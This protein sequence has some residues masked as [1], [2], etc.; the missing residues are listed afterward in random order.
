MF[1]LEPARE[2]AAQGHRTSVFFPAPRTVEERMRRVPQSLRRPVGAMYWFG[3]VLPRRIAQIAQVRRFD[4]IVL[5]CGLLRAQSVPLLDVLLLSCA[6][7]LGV[8]SVYH[9]DDALYEVVKPNRYAIRCRL[10]DRVATGNAAIAAFASSH[11]GRV[12]R[13]EGWIDADAYAAAD[14][15][16]RA[17][18]IGWTGH[19]PR[20][21]LRPLLNVFRR[22][23]DRYGVTIRVIGDEVIDGGE[24]SFIESELWQQRHE[25]R[26]FADFDIGVMPL[27]N[28]PYN[29]GKEA[30]KLKEYM[31]AGL[32]VVCSPVG[33]NLS[34]VEE[35]RT[36][37]FAT[38]EDEW[39]LALTRL[40]LDRDLRIALGTAGRERALNSYSRATYMTRLMLLL[41]TLT[42]EGDTSPDALAFQ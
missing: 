1:C 22:L 26:V 41:R 27:E 8:R 36:G 33:H 34:V 31:A 30:F 9:L 14:S 4:V 13:M 23:R 5:Y 19:F 3:Y 11:G 37:L 7:L 40:I 18:V 20:R 24:W 38:T 28:T 16:E 17:C 10:A 42:T 32:P 35:E 2:L 12:V 29:R 25:K 39:E 15:D 21:R 6:R